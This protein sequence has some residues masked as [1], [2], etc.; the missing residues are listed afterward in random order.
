V[1]YTFCQQSLKLIS[2]LSIID[3]FFQSIMKLNHISGFLL[4]DIFRQSNDIIQI[5]CLNSKRLLFKNMYKLYHNVPRY[6][7]HNKTQF[8]KLFIVFSMFIDSSI[9]L[10]LGFYNLQVLQLGECF[11]KPID[12]SNNYL[13]T[14]LHLG[15]NFDHS[16]DVSKNTQLMTLILGDSFNQFLDLSNNKKLYWFFIR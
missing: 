8:T 11:D 5:F 16:L 9:N 12:V 14:S 10:F 4:E 2:N 7:N 13:L 6:I 15:N 1:S 3:I